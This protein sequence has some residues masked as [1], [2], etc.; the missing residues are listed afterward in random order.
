[1]NN[2]IT[3][4]IFLA[5]LTVFPPM[6]VISWSAGWAAPII[7]FIAVAIA[8][9]GMFVI[10]IPSILLL[11]RYQDPRWWHL[12]LVGAMGAACPCWA[13]GEKLLSPTVIFA[14]AFGALVAAAAWFIAFYGLTKQ[15]DDFE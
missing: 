3:K 5:P 4:A 12:T 8:Y 6:T 2:R 13:T 9:G 15:E 1:M 7:G 11:R 10:G 14:G